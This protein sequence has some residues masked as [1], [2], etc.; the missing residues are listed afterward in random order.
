MSGCST[1]SGGEA[2][3]F[4]LL[5]SPSPSHTSSPPCCLHTSCPSTSLSFLFSIDVASLSARVSQKTLTVPSVTEYQDATADST[6]HRGSSDV[7]L[8]THTEKAT[9]TER[10]LSYYC[11]IF[12]SFAPCSHSDSS[13]MRGSLEARVLHAQWQRGQEMRREEKQ[14]QTKQRKYFLKSQIKAK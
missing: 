1:A 11:H 3:V 7:L 2:L 8:T 9:K 10:M 12:D 6:T 5:L 13:W 14:K 4:D